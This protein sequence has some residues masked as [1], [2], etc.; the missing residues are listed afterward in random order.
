MDKSALLGR[1]TTA[2]TDTVDVEVDG[3]TVTVT[4]RGLSR[5]EYVVAT[6]GDD[7]L[8]SER[9]LLALALVDPVMAEHD[10]A[11]WQKL[12]GTTME[13]NRVCMKVNELSGIGKDA[14]K[15]E[16]PGAGDQS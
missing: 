9:R 13:I 16:V 8:Q 10:V 1:S 2:P 7:Q 15:S 6:K 14:A 5:A 4:V 12:P 3:E 11:A